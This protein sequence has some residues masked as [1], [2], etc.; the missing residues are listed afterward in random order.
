VK[1]RVRKQ[2][3][4][5]C[6]N[7]S[8]DIPLP[9]CQRIEDVTNTYKNF[10]NASRYYKGRTAILGCPVPCQQISYS[11]ELSHMH[12]NSVIGTGNLTS[13]ADS[14]QFYML[15]MIFRSLDIEKHV[16]T[17]VYDAGNF[18]AA[19]GGNLGLFLGFSCLSII[20]AG[21]DLL[22]RICIQKW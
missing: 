7:Q 3:C 20:F 6:V 11:F 19:V 5:Q 17:L 21:I 15:M 16:E 12:P 14:E 18:F 22:V 4:Q 1:L 9:E 8:Q 2:N 13:V 10:F